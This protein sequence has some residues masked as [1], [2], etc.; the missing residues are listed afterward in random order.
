MAHQTDFIP[1]LR[2]LFGLFAGL[3]VLPLGAPPATAQTTGD[4][5]QTLSQAFDDIE[6]DDPEI[7]RGAAILLGKYGQQ[8]SVAPMLLKAL[9]DPEAVVRR[10]AVISLSE[11]IH[12]LGPEQARRLI[13]SLEDPDPEV[14]LGVAAWLPQVVLKASRS[15]QAG[16]AGILQGEARSALQGSLL[17]ALEDPEPRVRLQALE[18]VRFL[19]WRLP[20]ASLL[21]ML[22]DASPEV[23]LAAVDSL[24]HLLSPLALASALLEN[25]PDPDTAVRLK[26]AEKLSQG[27]VPM[28][29]Q[30][31]LSLLAEDEKTSVRITA[32]IGRFLTHPHSGVPP[33]LRQHLLN[34]QWDSTQVFA[35]FNGL[36]SLPADQRRE[37]AHDLLASKSTAV[38]LEA[39]RTWLASF[40]AAPPPEDLHV[41]M[42]DESPEIRQTTLNALLALRADLGDELLRS[43]TASPYLDV[44][45]GLFP[46]AEAMS[47][48][49]KS[50]FFMSLLLDTEAVV[51]ARALQALADLKPAQ[52][53]R[54]F[55]ASLRDP[56]A[57]VRR[58]AAR[59]LASTLGAEGQK[60]LAEW[61]EQHPD[62]DLARSFGSI[63][64]ESRPSPPPSS[65]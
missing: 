62:S 54:I 57:E 58:A 6:S 7:R 60:L 9:E 34:H 2:R 64:P 26:L 42:E 32:Q 29:L 63:S 15:L 45:L 21:P 27:R 8:V 50:R 65:P 44:R 53:E 16:S 49:E 35:F 20:Q 40:A 25:W 3:M 19:P 61:I 1:S 36:R 28:E 43:L 39:A 51:R 37:L 18:A 24:F 52:W 12:L 47:E 55:T 5:A 22:M 59:Q 17:H 13:S 4:L 10:A 33:E 11:N 30:P 14:R 48:E 23:R 41:L 31:L 46:L 56:S 38:R